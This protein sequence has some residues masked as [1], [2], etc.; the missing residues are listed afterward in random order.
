MPGSR[1]DARHSRIL[2]RRARRAPD[3]R[4]A[5]IERVLPGRPGHVRRRGED[6]AGRR[7]A[8]RD[9][10]AWRRVG[11]GGRRDGRGRPSPDR[12]RRRGG[13]HRRRRTRRRDRSQTRR[14][15]LRGRGRWRWRRPCAAT[16]GRPTVPATSERARPPRCRSCSSA[17]PPPTRDTRRGRHRRGSRARPTSTSDPGRAAPARHRGGGCRCEC[18]CAAGASRRRH[19]HRMRCGRPLAVHAGARR[20]GPDPRTGNTIRRTSRS[21]RRPIGWR[22]R[23]R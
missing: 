10:G 16:C 20:G 7:P 11:P 19:R 8:A 4:G 1:T 5:R 2:H 12:G 15:D 6:R 22:S 17:W 23:R 3:H 9:R 21:R 13:G 18:G 14:A